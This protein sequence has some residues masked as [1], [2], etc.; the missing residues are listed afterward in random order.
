[1][2]TG[3]GGGISTDV[4]LSLPSEYQE[5]EFGLRTIIW[6]SSRVLSSSDESKGVLL[7]TFNDPEPVRKS[8]DIIPTMV[9]WQRTVESLEQSN[10]R[11]E[12]TAQRL[13]LIKLYAKIPEVVKKFDALE[14]LHDTIPV[15]EMI[16]A[17]TKVGNKYTSVD[18]TKGAKVFLMKAGTAM[19]SVAEKPRKKVPC[20]FYT[21]GKCTWGEKCRWSHD[22]KGIVHLIL[23][24]LHVYGIIRAQNGKYVKSQKS[25]GVNGDKHKSKMSGRKQLKVHGIPVSDN[26]YSI[27][28]A[29]GC[30]DRPAPGESDQNEGEEEKLFAQ[31]AK[32]LKRIAEG[33]AATTSLSTSTILSAM[34]TAFLQRNKK[35]QIAEAAPEQVAMIAGIIADTAATAR[36]AGEDHLHF[37]V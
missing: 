11:Q 7:D 12:S 35:E 27:L 6:N 36:I 4:L 17:I 13:S 31:I 32:A 16:K 22:G 34:N 8:A 26:M 28:D 24:I 1:M 5:E 21:Q 25:R 33:V 10:L 19:A 14:A 18:K 3:E 15:M 29:G 23:W 20:R 37:T 9:D 30:V 2:V